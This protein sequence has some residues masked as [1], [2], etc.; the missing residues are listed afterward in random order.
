VRVLTILINLLVWCGLFILLIT[1]SLPRHVSFRET[2]AAAITAAVGLVIVQTL[3]GYL[4]SRELKNLDALYSYFALA[5]GLLFWIYLQIQVLFYALEIA[6][7]K[8]QKLWPRSLTDKKPTAADRR[9]AAKLA[10]A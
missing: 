4:L 7:V 10:D 3:G 9:L 5:L 1:L 2:R 8:S 6:A